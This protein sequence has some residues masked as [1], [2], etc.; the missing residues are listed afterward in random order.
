MPVVASI[1]NYDGLNG[2]CQSVNMCICVVWSNNGIGKLINDSC[3]YQLVELSVHLSL[4]IYD[5]QS[6]KPQINTYKFTKFELIQFDLRIKSCIDGG[7]LIYF[8]NY[9]SILYYCTNQ[10]KMS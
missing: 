6:N 10:L 2:S 4:F 5:P 7:N 1:V 8:Q 9:Y 3:L